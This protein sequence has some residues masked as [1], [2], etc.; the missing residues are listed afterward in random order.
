MGT[1]TDT[2]AGRERGRGRTPDRRG[3][4]SEDSSGDGN[5]DEDKGNG[6]EDKIGEGGREAK[7]RKKPH[8]SCRRHVVNGR[9]MGGKSKKCRK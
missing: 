5:E 7:K 4:G 1:G 8:N 2:R 3:D 6:N 9:N